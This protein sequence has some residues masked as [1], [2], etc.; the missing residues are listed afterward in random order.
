L[1]PHKFSSIAY[2]RLVNFNAEKRKKKEYKIR[3][4]RC[5]EYII[6]KVTALPTRGLVP[7]ATQK[8]LILYLAYGTDSEGFYFFDGT[9]YRDVSESAIFYNNATTAHA[10][11]TTSEIFRTGRTRFGFDAAAAAAAAA[12]IS[13][14]N[15]GTCF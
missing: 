8:G 15:P 7:T 5:F 6:P 11:A 12:V 2:V 10:T 3:K 13:I 4:S 14:E 1:L 9:T